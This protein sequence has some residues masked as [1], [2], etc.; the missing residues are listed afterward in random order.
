L[1]RPKIGSIIRFHNF[2]V[3][4]LVFV[5]DILSTHEDD[6]RIKGLWITRGVVDNLIACGNPATCKKCW[7]ST[8]EY[9]S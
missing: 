4:E 5:I 6:T 8:W 3:G 1:T 9:V 7:Y 2:H